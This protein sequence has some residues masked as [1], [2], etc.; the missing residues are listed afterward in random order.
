MK[1]HYNTIAS[2]TREILYKE[3]GSK[4]YATAFPF[5]HEEQLTEII[6]ML[7]SAHH[8]A[9]HHCYA[10]K[11]GPTGDNYRSNDDGEPTH[12]AGDPILSQINALD[13]SDVLVVVSR[14]FGGT[15]LGVGGLIQSY[16]QAARMA[17]DEGQVIKRV[18]TGCVTVNFEYAQMSQVMRF[19]EENNFSIKE[20][21]LSLNCEITLNIPLSKVETTVEKLNAMYPIQARS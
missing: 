19:I 21:K 12:S 1:D 6:K 2:K 8:K 7:R 16:R 20:Q 10:W 11:I 3:R 14:I 15:K 4:F 5:T 13:M 9:G 18:V 17:L